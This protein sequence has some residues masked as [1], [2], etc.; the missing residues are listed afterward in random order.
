MRVANYGIAVHQYPVCKVHRHAYF[1]G[2][3]IV[4]NSVG[5]FEVGMFQYGL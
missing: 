4:V 2:I 3:S 5:R 1:V